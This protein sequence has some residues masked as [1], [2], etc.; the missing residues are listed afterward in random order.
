MLRY[1]RTGG[2]TGADQAAWRAARRC[3]LLTCGSMPPR[4][5]TE[6]GP[7]PE[8]ARDYGAYALNPDDFLRSDD[9]INWRL[10]YRART[11]ANIE[12]SEGSLLFGDQTSRGS[13]LLIEIEREMQGSSPCRPS[14]LCISAYDPSGPRRVVDWL[15]EW[16]VVTLNVAGNRESSAPGIGAWVERYLVEVF[17][18]IGYPIVGQKG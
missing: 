13:Q 12:H 6:D 8:F 2:Q 5:M 4:Y 3:G 1:V 7:R 17:V 18:L 14:P 11:R 15:A 16:E 9:A 10:A